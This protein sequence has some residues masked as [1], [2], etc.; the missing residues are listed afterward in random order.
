VLLDLVVRGGMG[1]REVVRVLRE[2]EPGL[3]AALMTGHDSGTIF[4]DYERF[5]F[6][7]AISK[8]FTIDGLRSTLAGLLGDAKS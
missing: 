8:P 4:K 5:G 3:R 6:Q 1:G 2:M 7:A